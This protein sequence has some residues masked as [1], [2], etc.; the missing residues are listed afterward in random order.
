MKFFLLNKGLKF[1]AIGLCV[2]PLQI[3]AEADLSGT[4]D[5]GSGIDFVR[6]EK[7][8]NSICL[9][10][11]DTEL[12]SNE[13][14]SSVPPPPRVM[15]KP[16]RPKYRTEFQAKVRDLDARQVAKDPVIRCLPPGVPR[17][18][19]PDKIV[20]TPG[21]IVF[22]YD[23]VSGNFFR[24]IP[25]DGRPHRTDI[26]ESFLGDAIGWWEGDTLVVESVNFNAETWLTDDGSFHTTDLKVIERLSIEDDILQ[27][28][29]TA[30]DPAILAEPWVLRPRTA[31]RT[32]SEILE[33]ALCLER[34]LEHMVD[35]SHH[36]N[37]R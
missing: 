20:Q 18:G 14:E 24:I 25:T 3:T 29:A 9:M 23:D 7:I 35:D 15:P 2:M 32:D 36:T 28:Q 6:P 10:G 26:E 1:I 37:P 13:N 34:D 5:N 33:A 17:I 19:P 4:W 21:E 27:W 8:G 22:L 31:I 16:D 11:C 30:I 12:E